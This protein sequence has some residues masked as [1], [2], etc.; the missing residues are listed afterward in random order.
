MEADLIPTALSRWWLNIVVED[1]ER[2]VVFQ[3]EVPIPLQPFVV[4]EIWVR[5]GT[6]PL[7]KPKRRDDAGRIVV[8]EQAAWEGEDAALLFAEDCESKPNVYLQCYLESHYF[9]TK[10]K[11]SYPSIVG[12]LVSRRFIYC[13]QHPIIFFCFVLF[14]FQHIATCNLDRMVTQS[15]FACF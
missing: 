2:G 15:Q 8:P 1:P 7:A 13:F 6:I 10:K 14:C 11:K 5:C 12:H 3:S 9:S 4:K